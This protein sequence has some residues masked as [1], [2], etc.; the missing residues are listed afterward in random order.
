MIVDL[1]CSFKS[2]KLSS[3]L[4]ADL[5][6]SAPVG[7]SAKIK[8]G[9]VIIALE[10]AVRAFDHLKSRLDIYQGFL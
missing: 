6:S 3:K 4:V 8:L 10:A 9:A 5:E 2:R 7:S 1:S